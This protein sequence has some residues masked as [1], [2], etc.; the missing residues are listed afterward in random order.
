MCSFI[1]T[2][3]KI[4][5]IER[6][7]WF[8]QKRGPDI[9]TNYKVERN[10]FIHNLL[11]ITGEVGPQPL[12][13][14]KEDIFCIYNG[15]IY[16]YKKLDSTAETDGQSIITQYEE[17]GEEVFKKL[18]GEFAI[19][20]VDYKKRLLYLCTDT[21]ATK[22]IWMSRDENRYCVTSYESVLKN[23]NFKNRVK[24]S[25]NRVIKFNLD[26]MELQSVTK[27]K[28]FDT[29]S[30]Y[31]DSFKD[32]ITSFEQSIE[33]RTQSVRENIFIGLSGGYDSGA[34]ACELM[35][36]R[37]PF[38]A[39]S[40]KAEENEQII[41]KRHE[42]LRRTYED[43]SG[44]LIHLS[45]GQYLEA[46]KKL[47]LNA[48]EFLYQIVRNGNITP[49]E[50][51]TDDKGS[52]GLSFICEK[53]SIEKRKIYLS[54]QGADEI[55]SDYGFANKK[56]YSHSTIGG[57][58]PNNIQDIFP[59]NNFYKSTQYSYLGKEENVPGA[60]GI[61]GRYPFL[62]FKVVQE[63]L[64]LSPRLKNSKYKAPLQEYL[65]LNNFPFTE[66]EKVGFSCDKNLRN[67]K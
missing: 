36:K 16:N 30:Q 23:L 45:V 18:D 32:W 10:Y 48:E 25:E 11:S 49:N 31:K 33:K 51:M 6:V 13:N 66:G 65:S 54:G 3:F 50:F 57:Y 37:I 64:W 4:E 59:W 56:I 21:F 34:I 27:L 9:T 1:F 52:V 17:C 53:A 40:I 2:N 35:K 7:N 63:F 55:F 41:L 26:T 47:K 62:D 19:V 43:Y 12:Y 58:F 22:P 20:L 44:E 8:N 39:Y 24:L 61:E 5:N 29:S 60:W 38:K 15:E 67:K 42:L 46:Q 28:E 14:Q